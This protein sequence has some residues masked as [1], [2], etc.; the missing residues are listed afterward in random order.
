MI[1]SGRNNTE[2]KIV[3]G[4][5]ASRVINPVKCKLTYKLL[6]VKVCSLFQIALKNGPG[7]VI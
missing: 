4:Y 7:R 3:K 6:L 2:C 5:Q 1:I